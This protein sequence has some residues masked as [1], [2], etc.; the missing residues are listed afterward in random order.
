MGASRSIT[1]TDWQ[2][3]SFFYGVNEELQNM[4]KGA[5][6]GIEFDHVTIE[7]LEKFQRAFSNVAL[8]DIGEPSMKLRMVKSD[9]E[10]DLIKNGARIADIGKSLIIY[11]VILSHK[12]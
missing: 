6:I 8:V 2:R 12:S 4:P 9:E 3:D 1:F 11:N 10:I 5:N 7:R